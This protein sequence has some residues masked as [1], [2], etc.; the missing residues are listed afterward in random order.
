M[1]YASV[2]L[3]KYFNLALYSKAT[4]KKSFDEKVDN[5]FLIIMNTG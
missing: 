1:N 4:Y 5:K 3:V 2:S